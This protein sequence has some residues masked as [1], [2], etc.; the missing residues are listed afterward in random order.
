MQGFI[1]LLILLTIFSNKAS[2]LEFVSLKANLTNLRVGPGIDYPVK[3]VY[4]KKYIPLEKIAEYDDWY[5]VKDI[6]NEEGWVNK[7]LLLH[8]SYALTKKAVQ[9]YLKPDLISTPLLYFQPRVI[10]EIKNC[11]KNWCLIKPLKHRKVWILRE[12]LWGSA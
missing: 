10:V 2:A 6:D 7:K 8:K 9:G 1:Y 3:W 12:D 4:V 11:N 5:K